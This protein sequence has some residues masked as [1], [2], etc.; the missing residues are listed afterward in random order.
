M[1]CMEGLADTSHLQRLGFCLVFWRL[2]F[3]QKK[4]ICLEM[5]RGCLPTQVRL[6]GKCFQCPTN[7][8]SCDSFDE[9]LT[10]MFFTCPFAMQFGLRLAYGITSSKMPLTLVRLQKQSFLCYNALRRI[11]LLVL[12]V[13]FGAYGSIAS[14][15][16]G[17]M[18]VRQMLKY[19]TKLIDC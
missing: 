10:R 12:L 16:C 13:C 7:C 9:D 18:L 1:L 6:Q 5:C 8:V 11:L 3:P 4:K 14:S 15:K 17:M 2:K 19:L